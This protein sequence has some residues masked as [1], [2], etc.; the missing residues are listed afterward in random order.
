[1]G[2]LKGFSPECSL[3][4]RSRFPFCV[5]EAPHWLHWNG[6]SPANTEIERRSKGTLRSPRPPPSLPL[7]PVWLRLC[8]ISTLGP[9]QTM[10]HISHLSFPLG[11]RAGPGDEAFGLETWL[12]T[13]RFCPPGP[14]GSPPSLRESLIPG[15]SSSLHSS[16]LMERAAQGGGSGGDER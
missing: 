6:L 7:L 11:R 12:Q 9:V 5:K 15:N 8:T 10:P 16:T 4:W 1:M 14:A 13:P 3:M 2:H